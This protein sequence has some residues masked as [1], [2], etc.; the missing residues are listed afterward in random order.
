MFSHVLALDIAGNP[1]AW[2][3]PHEAVRY[4][5][6]GKVAWD[7]GDAL[8]VWHGGFSKA[9]LR[10]IIR[11]RPVIAIAGSEIMARLL[12]ETLPLGD[13]NEM[14]FKRDRYTCAYCG[15]T[16]PKRLLTRDHI[17][18]T[19][20]GGL[21]RWEN[22]VTSCGPCNSAKGAKDLSEFR[23]LMYVPYAPCRFEHFILSGRNIVADQMDYLAARLPRHSRVDRARH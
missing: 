12:R 17:V 21:D 1:F 16:F 18:A 13:Q 5:A 6:T 14:L 23:P 19:S 9:G 22:C 20:K 11:T 3:E 4:Y 2:L 10:S 15:G 8:L 7:V